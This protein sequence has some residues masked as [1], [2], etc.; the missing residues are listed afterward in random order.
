[1]NKPHMS[2]GARAVL[3]ALREVNMDAAYE[4]VAVAALR[5]AVNNVLTAQQILDIAA[6]LEDNHG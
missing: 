6:E 2:P 5:A 3:D 1:M 4:R